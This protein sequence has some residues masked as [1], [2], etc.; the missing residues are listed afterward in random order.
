VNASRR[1][2]R[3]FFIFIVKGKRPQIHRKT[4]QFSPTLISCY[5]SCTLPKSCQSGLLYRRLSS[6]WHHSASK[7]VYRDSL[8]WSCGRS[9]N[10]SINQ[11]YLKWPKWWKPLQGPLSEEVTVK[12]RRELLHVNVKKY[13]SFR[14]R[15]VAGCIFSV[16][17]VYVR[18]IVDKSLQM[19]PSILWRS[20]FTALPYVFFGCN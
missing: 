16:C 4:H 3:P 2:R 15:T 8:L 18:F 10:Q 13:C 20:V 5:L 14:S 1:R 7:C 12:F 19:L 11:N 9:I 6:S 17:A